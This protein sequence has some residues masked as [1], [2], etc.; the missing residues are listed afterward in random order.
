MSKLSHRL[1]VCALAAS[2]SA[3]A[4]AGGNT[5]INSDRTA[6]RSVLSGVFAAQQSPGQ[7]ATLSFESRDII[8]QGLKQ[9]AAATTTDLLASAGSIE[10]PCAISG[11]LRARMTAT[12]PRV[13]QFEWKACASDFFGDTATLN[14][15][16]EVVLPGNSFTPAAIAGLRLGDRNRDLVREVPRANDP[17]YGGSRGRWNIR[18][19]GILPMV[20]AYEFGQFV[21]RYAYETSGFREYT[22]YYPSYPVPGPPF[23]AQVFTDTAEGVVVAGEYTYD[24]VTASESRTN[25][26][27]RGKLTQRIDSPQTPTRAPRTYIVTVSHD[28]FRVR[29]AVVY[30]LGG[31]GTSS[32]SFDGKVTVDAAQY[33]GWRGCTQADTFTYR[34]RTPLSRYLENIEFPDHGE[35]VVN[36]KAVAKF[37][38]TGVEPYVDMLGHLD[39]SVRGVGKFS[40]SA[41]YGI[42]DFAAQADCKP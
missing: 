12:W 1:V 14:G 22:S 19:I 32:L 4:I 41:P 27:V 39:L 34:T 42:I 30:P 17:N 24:T 20:R 23:Y 21:G 18:A 28:D 10:I 2:L 35:I 40:L 11:T 5:T 7:I 38:I 3:A 16:A 36:D 26:V 33:Y 15:P 37:S 6:L 31:V 13:V 9:I 29:D 25:R 8:E